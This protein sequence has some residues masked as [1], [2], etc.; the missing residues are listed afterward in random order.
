MRRP[1]STAS[2]EIELAGWFSP[3]TVPGTR[4]A[5]RSARAAPCQRSDARCFQFFRGSHG[6]NPRQV[7]DPEAKYCRSGGAP[8]SRDSASLLGSSGLIPA[9]F[10]RRN[11]VSGARGGPSE[12]PV[13]ARFGAFTPVVSGASAA[14]T[15]QR[16]SAARKPSV[17]AEHLAVL[18]PGLGVAGR[19][20][21]EAGANLRRQE[22][23]RRPSNRCRRGY[24]LF[25]ASV[26][27]GLATKAGWCRRKTARC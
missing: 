25:A 26:P 21:L 18:K 3:Y 9:Q 1:I 8:A 27:S 14:G 12:L 10:G 11:E 7:L 16:R 6:L 4:P 23:I 17:D 19:V 24:V 13:D 2:T 20:H 15:A 22:C 5:R